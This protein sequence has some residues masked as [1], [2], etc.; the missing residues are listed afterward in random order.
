MAAATVIQASEQAGQ[1]TQS[2]NLDGGHVIDMQMINFALKI[3][4]RAL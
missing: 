3:D 1:V 4:G 2:G